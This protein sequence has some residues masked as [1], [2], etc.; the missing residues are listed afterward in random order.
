MLAAPACMAHASRVRAVVART[1]LRAGR[2]GPTEAGY[3]PDPAAP[4]PREADA[5]RL[6]RPVPG[7]GLMAAT[8]RVGMVGGGQLARM[9][10]AAAIDLG[11]ALHVLA[12]TPTDPAVLAGASHRI[13]EP[14]DLDALTAFAREVDVLTLDHELVEATHLE[15]LAAAGH[16]IRPHAAALLHAKDKL[17]ARTRLGELG[18][19]VPPF[20][21]VDDLE[22]VLAFTAEHQWPVVMK[23]RRGG[24]DG[25][26]VAVVNGPDQAADVLA[27][28]GSWMVET[29]VEIDVEV[30][31]LLARRPGGQHVTYPLIETVQQDGICVELIQPA[32]VHHQVAAAAI[33]LGTRVADAVDGVG[34]I[35]VELFISGDGTLTINELALRPHNSGHATIEGS[36]TSQFHNHLRAVLDW[37]LGDTSMRTP[38]ATLVNLLG[39]DGPDQ[40]AARLPR[41]LEVSAAQVHLYG[42]ASR[43]G[44]KI[45]HITVLGDDVEVARDQAWTATQH[46]VGDDPAG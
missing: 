9:T 3:A 31:V 30:A 27:R 13:G 12:A 23:A 16:T 8:A 37:P 28:G 1:Y 24:Y 10:H 11:I 14:D 33:A 34:I 38:V 18:L 44:R 22:Q 29:H 7:D 36:T 26:G 15:A 19:P 45:G 43:P 41:A 42:K 32:R 5:D 40:I 6:P 20:A 4:G 21:P 25:R 46:L 35:A 39:P 17:H 2:Q